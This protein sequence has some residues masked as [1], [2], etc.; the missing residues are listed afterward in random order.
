[1]RLQESDDQVNVYEAKT[2][3]C[4]YL[5]KLKRGETILLCRRN[6]PIAEIRP[7]PA[8][9]KSK[10]PIGLSKGKFKVDSKFFD[11]LPADIVDSFYGR[12]F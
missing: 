9:R 6:V 1:V 5:Q 11:P 8:R 4:Y 2:H 12:G 3:L 10:P 7:L